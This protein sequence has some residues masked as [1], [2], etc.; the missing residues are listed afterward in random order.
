MSVIVAIKHEGVIYFGFDT[1]NL[2]SYSHHQI[3]ETN[4]PVFP[5]NEFPHALMGIASSSAE[6]AIL[7]TTAPLVGELEIIHKVI[8][9]KWVVRGLVPRIW[10]RLY[11]YEVL[12]MDRVGHPYLLPIIFAYQGDLYEINCDGY[13]Q[14]ISDYVVSSDMYSIDPALGVLSVSKN[15][16]PKER[17]LEALKAS[18]STGYNVDAKAFIIINTKD[19]KYEYY[20]SEGVKEE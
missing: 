9:L 14:E 17:I 15:Q 11:E 18:K 5:L 4:F 1:S 10:Q 2:S 8:N 12:Y 7:K 20:N 16:D 19:M 13:V 3:M 6:Q